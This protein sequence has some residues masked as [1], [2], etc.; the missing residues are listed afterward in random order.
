MPPSRRER[1][2]QQTVPMRLGSLAADLARI[3]S[4]AEIPAP[5][6]VE[7]LMAESKAFIEWVVPDLDI[8]PAARLVDIQRG[9]VR[10]HMEWPSVQN[11][12]AQRTELAKQAQAWSDEILSMS[13]LL[14]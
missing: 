6:A 12:A 4:F 10:W 1:Y 2:L 5:A 8:E 7:S 14:R 13:G 11:D 9:V 3:S